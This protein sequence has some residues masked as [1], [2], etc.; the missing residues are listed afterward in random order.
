MNIILLLLVAL[1]AV[2][3]AALIFRLA[4]REECHNAAKPATPPETEAPTSGEPQ[5]EG[6]SQSTPAANGTK[7]EAAPESTDAVPLDGLHPDQAEAPK[8]ISDGD[9]TPLV[10]MGFTRDQAFEV[11]RNRAAATKGG[12]KR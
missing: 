10:A 11:L 7:P 6:A 8:G 3:A 2:I 12:K 4:S 5:T 1:V 9:V